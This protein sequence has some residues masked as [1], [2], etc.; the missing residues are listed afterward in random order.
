MLFIKEGSCWCQFN[1]KGSDPANDIIF[2]R[3]PHSPV[4][5]REIIESSKRTINM[6]KSD[7]QRAVY[8]ER[9]RLMFLKRNGFDR[10]QLQ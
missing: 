2:V 6:Y 8:G 1:C 10:T 9:V 4:C 7:I 5:M 3:Q